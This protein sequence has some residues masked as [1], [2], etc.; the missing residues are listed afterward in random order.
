[1]FDISTINGIP[2]RLADEEVMSVCFARRIDEK[3]DELTMLAKGYLLEKLVGHQQNTFAVWWRVS[4]IICSL[5]K[6]TDLL[7]FIEYLL[8]SFTIT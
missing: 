8:P 3:P 4:K 1:M 6:D 7:I 5:F 2:F